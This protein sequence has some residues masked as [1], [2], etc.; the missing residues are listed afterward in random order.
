[1]PGSLPG[2]V[3]RVAGAA[4]KGRA[5]LQA[6]QSYPL[7]GF[8]RSFKMAEG[9]LLANRYLAGIARHTAAPGDLL[10]V[11]RAMGM[12][13]RQMPAF[14][15]SF[16]AANAVHFGFEETADSGTF[17]VYLEFADRLAAPAGARTGAVLLHLAFKWDAIDNT[18]STVGRYVFHP[19]LT[20]GDILER[21]AS[22]Y[23]PGRESPYRTVKAI[24]EL[25]ATRSEK[26]PMY[27][28]VS[29]EGNARSSFDLNLHEAQATLAEI[30]PQ[31]AEM[32]RHYRISEEPFERLL[33]QVCGAKLGHLSG[34][35]ERGGKDFLTV[36]YEAVPS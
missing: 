14:L 24:L 35:V 22:T 18:R 1:M 2:E 26:P 8:E 32:Q 34:G 3:G 20:T 29:E 5:L 19:D 27:L 23:L 9:T 4:E 15:E 28:E 6:L 21:L 25:A 30:E 7:E 11:C 12:P 16:P 31:L 36:Y 13:E 17:K 33:A 10:G